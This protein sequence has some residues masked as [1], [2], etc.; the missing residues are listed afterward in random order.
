[1]DEEKILKENKYD[2]GEIYNKAIDE[3]AEFAKMKNR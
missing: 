2:L 3:V 1:M